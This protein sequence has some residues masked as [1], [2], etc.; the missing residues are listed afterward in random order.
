MS[1]T[2][3]HLPTEPGRL[4]P[5]TIKDHQ[6][7]LR[8]PSLSDR[9]TYDE[10]VARLD[11]APL[12]VLDLYDLLERH[13]EKVLDADAL[14]QLRNDL[15]AAE[16]AHI[17]AEQ[18]GSPPPV[19]VLAPIRRWGRTIKRMSE[20]YRVDLARIESRNNRVQEVMVRW[21]AWSRDGA[22]LPRSSNGLLSDPEWFDRL[23]D[24]ER[25]LLTQRSLYLFR[26]GPSAIKNSEAVSGSSAAPETTPAASGSIDAPAK[27]ARKSPGKRASSSGRTTRKR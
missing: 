3:T 15:L 25:R 4:I 16:Q 7:E 27:A 1:D 20:E 19:E 23:D 22:V 14:A 26:L 11:L 6:Y 10:E 21:L 24:D 5:A 8:V 17:M 2:E 9:Y 12:S 18:N 13:A